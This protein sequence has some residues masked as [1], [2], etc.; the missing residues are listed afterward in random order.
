[1]MRTRRRLSRRSD[2]QQAT[3]SLTPLIDMALTLLV[4]FMVATPML[5]RAIKV[6]LPKGQVD[7]VKRQKPQDE[8]MVHIDK[9]GTTYVNGTKVHQSDLIKTVKRLAAA[10]NQQLVTVKADEAVPY[11]TVVTLVDKLK[12][13][14][15]ISYV[16][17]AT[18][19]T[20]KA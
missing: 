8:I 1:M 15:G 17:L 12:H 18:Q 2:G 9:Q 13:V 4:I 6:E 5:H 20:R 10:H 16:A 3:I 7:E 19:P 14:G 11:G